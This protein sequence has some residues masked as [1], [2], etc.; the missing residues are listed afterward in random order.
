MEHIQKR[1]TPSP[2]CLATPKPA[3]EKKGW[4]PTQVSQRQHEPLVAM[5]ED[6]SKNLEAPKI[7]TFKNQETEEDIY[8]TKCSTGLE[9]LYLH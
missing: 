5:I 9:Y 8:Q 1:Q 6:V 7:S 2:A 4:N 3:L